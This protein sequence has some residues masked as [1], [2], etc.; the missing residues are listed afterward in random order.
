M[1]VLWLVFTLLLI[2]EMLAFLAVQFFQCCSLAHNFTGFSDTKLELPS[3]A[4]TAPLGS[5]CYH[6][7]WFSLVRSEF[8]CVWLFQVGFFGSGLASRVKS[9]AYDSSYMFLKSISE[10][11]FDTGGF[12]VLLRSPGAVHQDCVP[13]LLPGKPQPWAS[14]ETS[15]LS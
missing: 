4:S 5:F 15:C 1:I 6:K 13:L 9:P 14:W 10:T 11:C 8:D 7:C 12:T 2:T 3:P